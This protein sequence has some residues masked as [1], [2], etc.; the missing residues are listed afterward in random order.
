MPA[1]PVARRGVRMGGAAALAWAGGAV[2]MAG[3]ETVFMMS[4]VSNGFGW[5][6]VWREAITKSPP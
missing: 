1:R 3:K 4:S 2:A 6:G 5:L